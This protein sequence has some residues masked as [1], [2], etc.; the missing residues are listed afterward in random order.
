M[1]LYS[2][3][4]DL[5]KLSQVWEKVRSNN[6]SA[7]TD[8]ISCAQFDANSRIELK[9]LNL[10]LY[11]HEYRVR[12][13][14][15]VSLEKEEKVR[16]ISLYTMRDKVV[17]TSIAQELS[18]IYEPKF[19]PCVYAYRNDRSAMGAAERIEKEIG[20]GRYSW[21]AKTDIESFFDR[22]RVPL[23]KRKLERVIKEEDVLNL[24]EMQLARQHLEKAGH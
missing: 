4:I 21:I 20:S 10:E 9:Q 2:K 8:Q 5:Q 19:S 16:E 18:R 6:P 11:N 17:Q 7:G 12:P 3:I 22:I 23:L 13:V 1:G 15:L 14:R 24:I